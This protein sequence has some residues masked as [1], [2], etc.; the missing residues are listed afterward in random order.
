MFKPEGY[1]NRC[2]VCGKIFA[3]QS[4][5]SFNCGC[6]R[7]MTFDELVLFALLCSGIFLF[8]M[9]CFKQ[10][11]RRVN[12]LAGRV[13][14]VENVIPPYYTILDYEIKN[15]CKRCHRNK[16]LTN[17]NKYSKVQLNDDKYN[18]N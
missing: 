16:S 15:H 8:A 13:E 7:R 1:Q 3:A 14:R 18:K 2:V 12:D 11:D 10:V 5:Y 6:T 17:A 9:D 4:K